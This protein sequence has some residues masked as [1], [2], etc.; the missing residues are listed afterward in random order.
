[1]ARKAASN[2]EAFP[3]TSCEFYNSLYGSQITLAMTKH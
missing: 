1:M 2:T 3:F